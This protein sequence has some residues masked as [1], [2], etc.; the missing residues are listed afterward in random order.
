MHIILLFTYGYSLKMW[1]DSGSL[2]RELIYY[3]KLQD[4]YDLKFTFVTFGD[5]DDQNYVDFIEVIPVYK[6]IKKRKSKLLNYILSFYYPFLI[7]KQLN[8]GDIIKQNQL[9]GSW[10][11]IILK[12]IINKPLFVRTGYDM[13]KFSI[14]DKKNSG[15]KFLYKV[16]TKITLSFADLYTVSSQNDLSFICNNFKVKNKEK[17][18]VRPN[19]VEEIFTKNFNVR[20]EFSILNVGRLEMQKNQI[21]ILKAL[22]SLN[23]QL[24]IYGEGSKKEELIQEASKLNVKLT[25]K[26]FVSYSDLKNTYNNFKFFI[27]SSS[28]EGNPKVLLEAMSAGCIVIAKNIPNNSELIQNKIDGF[29]YDSLK[30]LK[31]CLYNIDQQKYD[32]LEISNNAKSNVL[33]KHSILTICEQEWNDIKNLVD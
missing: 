11:A 12:F 1:K 18:I 26:D 27:L 29:L 25:I 10:I 13:Y 28:F 8:E 16:L 19:W 31:Q 3:K 15:V 23:Y 21:E 33:K 6:F 24:T 32:L 9:L 7:K 14:N 17:L 5:E 30:D 22:D 4:A 2:D 20:N